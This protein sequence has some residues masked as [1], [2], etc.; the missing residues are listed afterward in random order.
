MLIPLSN[1]MAKYTIAS[2][3][4]QVPIISCPHD[5]AKCHIFSPVQMTYLT[6]ET[7]EYRQEDV[8]MNCTTLNISNHNQVPS[9]VRVSL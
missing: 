3:V 5:I 4:L 6:H 2:H 7:R 8:L 9:I 1:R